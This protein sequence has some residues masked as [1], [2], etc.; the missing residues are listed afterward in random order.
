MENSLNNQRNQTIRE[1][2]QFIKETRQMENSLINQRNQT[3]SELSKLSK[4]PDNRT[5]PRF[6]KESRHLRTPLFFEETKL[7]NMVP[8]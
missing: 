4:K 7:G 1:L 6:F 2:S 3:T 5:T 8:L